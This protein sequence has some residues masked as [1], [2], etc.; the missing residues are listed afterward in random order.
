MTLGK[1]AGREV[2]D[3]LI[4]LCVVTEVFYL[5]KALALFNTGT[6]D[7][8]IL[9]ASFMQV[10]H[11]PFLAMGKLSVYVLIPRQ[12]KMLIFNISHAHLLCNLYAPF[13]VSVSFYLTCHSLVLL[14]G[15]HCRMF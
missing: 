10:T 11:L 14:H 12:P 9:H 6:H 7:P 15:H 3:S 5:N 13:V 1:L 2:P 4:E 8:F